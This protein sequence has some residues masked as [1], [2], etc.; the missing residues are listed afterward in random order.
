M[1]NLGRVYSVA[2]NG[3]EAVHQYGVDPSSF[4]LILMDMSMPIMDGFVATET[5]R[6]MEDRGKWDRCRIIAVTGLGSEEDRKQAY[7]SGVDG[8]LLKPASLKKLRALI[9]E[10]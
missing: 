3:L 2:E 9:E 7:Q 1:K 10:P 6:A 8:F 4:E 5:I